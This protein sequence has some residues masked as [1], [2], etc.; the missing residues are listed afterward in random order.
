MTHEEMTEMYKGSQSFVNLVESVNKENTLSESYMPSVD[1]LNGQP[2]HT[3]TTKVKSESEKLRKL[4]TSGDVSV[5]LKK[6]NTFIKKVAKEY[7]DVTDHNLKGAREDEK[8]SDRDT[9]L[10][11][12]ELKKGMFEYI[13]SKSSKGFDKAQ[14]TWLLNQLHRMV[15]STVSTSDLKALSISI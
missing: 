9:Y 10:S 2:K 11:E 13:L 5:V 7:F 6:A 3:P 14:S 8:S 15:S 4:F 1:T 12:L